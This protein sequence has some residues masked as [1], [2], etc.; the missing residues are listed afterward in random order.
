MIH[1][2]GRLELQPPHSS[3]HGD[4]LTPDAGRL[5]GG[6][7]RLLE[8]LA[9]WEA[10]AAGGLPDRSALDPV[11]IGPY[12]PGIA[13]LDVEEGDFRFRL[14]GE[15]IRS[16]YGSLRGRSVGELL[17]GSARAEILAEHRSCAAGRPTLTRRAEPASDGTDWR[18]YWRLLLPFGREGRTSAILAA[19]Q[20]HS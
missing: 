4:M 7:A 17:S 15:E 16:R 9:W 20:F 11:E 18:R 19:M 6:P 10:K 8:L 3:S 13:L 5:A 2:T 14:T 1:R 12:L